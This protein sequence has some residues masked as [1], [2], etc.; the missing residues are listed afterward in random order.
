MIYFLN[1]KM[2]KEKIKNEIEKIRKDMSI[3]YPNQ[4]NFKYIYVRL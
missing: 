3:C 2:D 4:E 1:N